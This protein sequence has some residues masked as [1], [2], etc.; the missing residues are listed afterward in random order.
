MTIRLIRVSYGKKGT[1]PE[2]REY[3]IDG[4]GVVGTLEEYQQFFPEEEFLIID[5]IDKN[6]EVKKN[7]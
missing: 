7:A 2:D 1:P 3:T 4:K 6:I 5:N